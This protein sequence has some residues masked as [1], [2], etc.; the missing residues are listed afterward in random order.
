MLD[1][2]RRMITKRKSS[3]RID[4]TRLCP[5]PRCIDGIVWTGE[6][7]EGVCPVCK[8]KGRIS[9]TEWM[10]YTLEAGQETKVE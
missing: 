3:T 8:S 9:L 5:V 1:H 6:G 10:R 7:P 2:G 4:L